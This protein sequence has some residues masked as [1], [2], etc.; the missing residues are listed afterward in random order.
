MKKNILIICLI[1]I[2]I[3]CGLHR[4]YDGRYTNQ[5]EKYENVV[6]I[7]NKSFEN[8]PRRFEK[9]R[10]VP[11]GQ[12]SD[13]SP[14]KF[15][16][17]CEDPWSI[18]Q[19]DGNRYRYGNNPL[20]PFDGAFYVGIAT[21]G[22]GTK[23]IL[24]QKLSK[25]LEPQ[26]QYRL[27]FYVAHANSFYHMGDF[28]TP[29]KVTEDVGVLKVWGSNDGCELEEL[30]F[31]S[32]PIRNKDWRKLEMTFSPENEFAFIVFELSKLEENENGT[33]ILLDKISDIQILN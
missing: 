26:N 23:G 19:F 30:L 31:Q 29:P 4:T 24:S 17:N 13:A 14:P 15:W 6:Y 5:P 7:K 25:A 2:Q 11:G 1:L 9:Y 16:D 8:N 3:S 21:N 18:Y 22:N 32:H 27:S 12:E 20:Q 10:N 33:N 28:Q